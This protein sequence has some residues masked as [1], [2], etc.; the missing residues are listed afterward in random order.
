MPDKSA[1][2]CIQYRLNF[3]YKI[4]SLD[5]ALYTRGDVLYAKRCADAVD[6]AYTPRRSCIHERA[7]FR[8]QGRADFAYKIG[9]IDPDVYT[10]GDVLYAKSAPMP[11]I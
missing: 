8:I 10:R 5:P 7:V 1:V 9:S 4:G 6:L 2:S 3:A 11:S